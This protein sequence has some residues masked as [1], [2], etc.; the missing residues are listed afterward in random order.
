MSVAQQMTAQ[1][2]LATTFAERW[3]ELIDGEVVVNEPRW[4]HA[5]VVSTLLFELTQWTRGAEGRGAASV[6]I[7]VLLDDRNVYAPDILW[8]ASARAPNDDSPWPYSIPDLAIEVRSPSTWRYDVGAK[9]SAYERHGLPE[10]WLVDTEAEALLVFRRSAPPTA[11][12]DVSIEVGHG[13]L[14]ASPQLPAFSLAVHA[15]FP[16]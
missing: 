9:K 2:Y 1:E 8:Y 6:P 7:D 13:E 14:I 10:L 11:S 16:E 15:L 4:N 3:V 12:F 5:R